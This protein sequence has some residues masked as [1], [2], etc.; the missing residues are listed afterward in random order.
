MKCEGC[1][2]RLDL[3]YFQII[4]S[5]RRLVVECPLCKY[6]TALYCKG[7]RIETA[8]EHKEKLNSWKKGKP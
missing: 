7:T 5:G 8:K 1:G 2:G 3:T 4:L 6:V